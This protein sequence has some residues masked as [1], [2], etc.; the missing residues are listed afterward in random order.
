ML[1]SIFGESMSKPKK[2]KGETI[3]D[4]LPEYL[5]TTNIENP[6]FV[7]LPPDKKDSRLKDIEREI[8]HYW[9]IIHPMMK[10]YM[11][12]LSRYVNEFGEGTDDLVHLRRS[13]DIELSN[14]A[15]LSDENRKLKTQISDLVVDKK[16]LNEKVEDLMKQR[17]TL[18]AEEIQAM[19][20]M[21]SSKYDISSESL[22]EM[23]KKAV[24]ETRE[25]EEITKTR[26]ERAKMEK[27]LEDAKKHFEKTQT[28][29]GETFQKKILELQ[30]KIDDLE[31][32]LSK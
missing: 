26:E 6:V 4:H 15:Q 9:E 32:E 2:Y 31:E 3:F 8:V 18:T 12:M 10:E 14:S 27:E 21:V 17:P 20:L 22:E 13:L 5:P 1:F 16:V 19:K 24:Q 28:E 29:V 25:S 7:K 30:S 11:I 23:M